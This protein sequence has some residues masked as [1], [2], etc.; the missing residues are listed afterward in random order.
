M[1]SRSQQ[2]LLRSLRTRK[3]REEEHLFL[4]EGPRLLPELVDSHLEVVALFYTPEGLADA[5]GDELRHRLEQAGVHLD[6]VNSATIREHSDTVTPQGVLAVARIPRREWGDL[7][8]TGIL[9]LDGV[10][11]PGNLGT[12]VRTAEALGMEGAVSLPGT[13]DEWNPKAVRAAAGSI[14]RLPVV[15]AGWE[16]VEEELR[17]RGMRIWAADLEGQPV[18]RW[19]PP[20]ARLALVLGNEGRGVSPRILRSCDRRVRVPISG[21]ADSLNVA[22][23][24]ALLIDRIFGAHRPARDEGERAG[25]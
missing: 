5:G 22:V 4:V 18:D 13:V 19:E 17:A 20:P 7:P 24:G 9:V 12:L 25:A 8:D 11:D 10:Q 3:G 2:K 6:Q 14:F 16:S 15:H 1:P 21:R 23:A